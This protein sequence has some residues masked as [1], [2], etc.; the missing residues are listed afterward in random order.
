MYIN[1]LI[2]TDFTAYTREDDCIATEL[3]LD[4]PPIPIIHPEQLEEV[5]PAARAPALAHVKAYADHPRIMVRICTDSF[6]C[7]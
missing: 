4:G 6:L 3:N 5:F 7:N 1:P 2:L